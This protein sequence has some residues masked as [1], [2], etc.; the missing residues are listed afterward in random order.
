MDIIEEFKLERE[1]RK[2]YKEEMIKK[3]RECKIKILDNEFELSLMGDPSN[4]NHWIVILHCDLLTL[5]EIEFKKYD[6]ALKYY[7]N[8]LIKYKNDI[9]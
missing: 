5:K 7:N 1:K 6:N 2:E 8:L 4:K 3:E 9:I